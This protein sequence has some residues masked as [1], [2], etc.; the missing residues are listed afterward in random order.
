MNTVSQCSVDHHSERSSQTVLCSRK[1][2]IQ[3]DP[4]K[5]SDGVV[6]KCKYFNSGYCRYTKKAIGCKNF[7]PTDVCKVEGCREKECPDRHPKK[8]KFEDECRYSSCLYNHV[9]K[10]VH[11]KEQENLQKE[12]DVL[13]TEIHNLKNENYVKINILAKVHLN[14]LEDL[15]REN[16]TLHNSIKEL[17]EK[18]SSNKSKEYSILLP[19]PNIGNIESESKDMTKLILLKYKCDHCMFEAKSV[20]GLKT[21]IG[22]MHKD[23]DL[24]E[25]ALFGFKNKEAPT[26][27]NQPPMKT[28]DIIIKNKVTVTPSPMASIKN[29][30]YSLLFYKKIT[31]EFST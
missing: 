2:Q 15:K 11:T 26:D 22:H 20:R 30:K 16:T 23:K 27:S 29:E 9:K 31:I 8:C 25:L 7:H 13:K 19:N 4:I 10:V 17:K 1:L 14:K 21:H 3:K 24:S 5:M 28:K 6:K 18:L 12:I